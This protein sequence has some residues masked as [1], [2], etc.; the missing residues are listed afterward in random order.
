MGLWILPDFSALIPILAFLGMALALSNLGSWPAVLAV[1]YSP[2]YLRY[3]IQ[4]IPDLL[5]VTF[6]C[7]GALFLFRRSRYWAWGLFGLA[8]A[9]KALTIFAVVPLLG[10][11]VWT[12]YRKVSAKVWS[13]SFALPLVLLS[14]PF[15]LWLVVI[16]AS[17]L[18]NPFL[19]NNGIENRHSGSL[20]L[21][22]KLSYWARFFTWVALKGVG[23]VLFGASLVRLVRVFRKGIERDLDGML[24]SWSAGVLV[25]WLLVRQGNYVHDYYTLPFAAPIALLG[26]REILTLRKRELKYGLIGISILIGVF[27][28]ARTMPTASDDPTLGRPQFCDW[29]K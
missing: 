22:F 9:T 26:A 7:L 3:S 21:L 11:D 10:W 17:D 1:M 8:V 13:L 6:L 24:S 16:F 15:I 2:I 20:T 27:N 4:H 14:F 25:Y 23:V 19:W 28:L 18:P 5:A 12:R 29:E